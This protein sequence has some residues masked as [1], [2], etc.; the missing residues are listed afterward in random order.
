MIVTIVL[1]MQMV[2]LDLKIYITM[3][4]ADMDGVGYAGSDYT[5]VV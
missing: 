1:M 5:M 3:I 4:Y 2:M